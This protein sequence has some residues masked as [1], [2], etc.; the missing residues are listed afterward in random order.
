VVSA[1]SEV[2]ACV[3]ARL[4]RAPAAPWSSA[5]GCARIR[6]TETSTRPRNDAPLL[7]APGPGQQGGRCNRQVKPMCH[8]SGESRHAR[9]PAR[10]RWTA[11][12][13]S[14]TPPTCSCTPG[15]RPGH[16]PGRPARRRLLRRAAGRDGAVRRG[17]ALVRAIWRPSAGEG[18]RR[19]ADQDA[20]LHRPG[21][22]LDA[23]AL[24][25]R[26]A[27]LG[28]TPGRLCQAQAGTGRSVT[29]CFI[30][31]VELRHWMPARR[32]CA[33]MRQTAARCGAVPAVIRGAAVWL[34]STR[35]SP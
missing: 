22:G 2:P 19:R 14:S 15:P 20:R 34:P 24:T 8:P 13:T 3:R 21:P 10:C 9:T 1:Q 4:R 29:T 35:S 12:S 30:T 33:R 7:T 6:T 32:A 28:A 23:A 27:D 18:R 25:L 11:R 16:R 5:T 31:S 17:H 26:P